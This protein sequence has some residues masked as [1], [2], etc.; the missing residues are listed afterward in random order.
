MTSIPPS[1]ARVPNLLVSNSI[2][3]N[4]T[5]ANVDLLNV[6]N[7]ISSGKR[8]S[9]P[10]EDPIGAGL[11]SVLNERLRGT[12]QRLRNFDHA[13]ST[14]SAVDSTLSE[15]GE[16]LL[17]AKSI[18]S[19]QIGVGSDTD[20]RKAQANVVESLIREL[21]SLSNS[22]FADIHLFGGRRTGA[23][24]F[25]AF[26]DGYR[27]QGEGDGLRTDLGSNLDA[28]ITLS[29]D[30]PFGAVSARIEGGVDLNPVLTPDTRIASLNGARGQGVSLG[31]VEIEID[32]GG[33]VTT[34]NVDLSE[35]ETIGDVEDIIESAIRDA[36]P[37]ALTGAFPTGV[38]INPAGTGLAFNVAG[39]YTID[40]RDPGGG[41]A[42]ADLG[43]SS[44]SYAGAGATGPDDLDPR[45][46]GATEFGD[47]DPASPFAAGD[48][49]FTNGGRTGTVTVG[50]GT[51]ISE[52]RRDVAQLGIGIR[53][54]IS[55]DGASLNIINEV[56]GA[57][58]SV[59]ES[60]AGTL[61]ATS[62]GI[63]SLQGATRL[64]D[65]NFGRGVE[66]AHGA[67]DPTTGLPD[68]DRNVDFEVTLT[69]GSTFT[70]DL[71]PE[72]NTDAAT[73]LARINAEAAA[74]GFTV[75]NGPG[76]IQAALSDG[77]NGI[78]IQ[79]NLGGGGAVSVASLNGH[80]AE[81]L[82]LLDGSFSAG[83]PA[84]FA[85]EDRST[86]RVDGAFSSLI[87]LRDALLTDDQRGI[88]FAGE[89]IE[90]DIERLSAT[91]GVVGGRLSRVEA[92]KVREEDLQ[93]LDQ[94]VKSSIEDLDFAEAS[95]RFSLLSL[96]LQAGYQTAGQTS[97][98]TLL[99]FL[100]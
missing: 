38:D 88:S 33:P 90:E 100:R 87:A 56:S 89:R 16:L 42:A 8:I 22:K 60:G 91:R 80:A 49:V 69:D 55:E 74:Q 50:A 9:R 39:G 95:S 92:A 34:I 12:D 6:Q 10:S 51:T 44:V 85:G 1:P 36:D 21:H 30:E 26:L 71:R 31:S 81:D 94:S 46:T 97:G 57:E 86:V 5:R 40:I 93:L 64:A 3:R 66:I 63:R 77:A 32:P 37:A 96:V 79:D 48:I 2:T 27:Y 65:F 19:D 75:G 98:L 73:L 84:V 58:L 15:A 4:I 78:T 59:E 23:A 53:A 24:P 61:T 54:E 70:V 20:T 47:L 35:A 82:G 11:L 13:S 43:L 17:Q 25:E 99:N 52:F 14:L 28:P 68:P 41:A 45:L 62:L 83:A 18:A 76:E 7:Q 29:G 67:I 72:D